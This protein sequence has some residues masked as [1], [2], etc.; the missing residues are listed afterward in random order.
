MD[1]VLELFMFLEV[2]RVGEDVDGLVDSIHLCDGH[3]ADMVLCPEVAISLQRNG[4]ATTK[5]LRTHILAYT[6]KVDNGLDAVLRENVL[7]ADSRQ[8]QDLGCL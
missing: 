5:V 3:Q 2:D 8:L 4:A 1:D 7:V 6:W